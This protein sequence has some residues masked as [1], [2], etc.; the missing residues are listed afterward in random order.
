MKLQN[1]IKEYYKENPL[2]AIL[3]LGFLFR[4]ISVLFSQGYG[5]SDDHFLIIEISQSWV[6]GFDQ[7]NWLP[8]TN[9]AGA[10][11]SGHSLFYT[12]LHYYL[13]LLLKSIGIT[14]P[15]FKMYIVRFL[16]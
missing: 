8:G 13:F 2:N 5:M 6:D 11:P 9:N 10:A 7:N 12:G 14:D 16:H 1:I 4:F 3:M 15:S